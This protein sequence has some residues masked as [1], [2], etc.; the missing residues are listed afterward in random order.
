MRASTGL[1]LALNRISTTGFPNRALIC[2][3]VLIT[4]RLVW[5][6]TPWAATGLPRFHRSGGTSTM[7]VA[8][9]SL[10]AA[11]PFSPE[12]PS[13][14]PGPLPGSASGLGS[15]GFGVVG[16]VSC[17]SCSFGS[18]AGSSGLGASVFGSSAF[19][20]LVSD[21]P[22]LGARSSDWSPSVAS[23]F[24]FSAVLVSICSASGFSAASGI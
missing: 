19:S 3:R 13:P 22:S 5:S 24:V 2:V 7:L 15:G 16:G 12:S 14:V 23:G 17:G 11:S 10:S 18:F 6:S 4:G 20:F 21:S 9:D 8:S 1:P